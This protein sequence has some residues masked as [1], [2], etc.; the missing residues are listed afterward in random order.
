MGNQLHCVLEIVLDPRCPTKQ[1]C[2][3]YVT[4]AEVST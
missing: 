1:V 2:C 3:F 4:Q